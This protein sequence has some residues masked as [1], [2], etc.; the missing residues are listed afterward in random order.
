[1][2]HE[3]I[4]YTLNSVFV[5]LV[6]IT[7]FIMVYGFRTQAIPVII[8]L[9]AEFVLYHFLLWAFHCTDEN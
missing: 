2:A 4:H 6:L 9:V 1:M 8:A 7:P 3:A 5:S